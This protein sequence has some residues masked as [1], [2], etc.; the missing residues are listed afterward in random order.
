M[1]VLHNISELIPCSTGLPR[2]ETGRILDAALAWQS[3]RIAWLG[4]ASELPSDFANEDVVDAGGCIVVPGLV[5]A[6]THLCFGGWRADEFEMRCRGVHYLDIARAGGGIMRTVEQTR[7]LDED[8]LF[9]QAR[10]RLAYLTTLG[11]T[12]V[13]CKSGYG[14]TLHDE[15]K[16]LR[17]YARLKALGAARIVSTFLGAHVVPREFRDRREDYVDLVC[18]EMLPAVASE[19]LA[20]YCDVFVEEG[21]FTEDEARRILGTAASLGLGSKLHV[22]QL[23]DVGGAALAAE[24]NAVSADHLEYTGRDGIAKMVEAGVVPVT[25]PVASL[26]LRQPPLDARQWI[27]AGAEVCV[28]T[29]FN[30]GTAPT[31]HLPLAMTLACT[32]NRMTPD[33]ALLG[34][35]RVAAQAIGLEE[36]AGSLEVGRRADFVLVDTPSV[37]HWLYNFEPNRA[38]ATFI[39][40]ARV[41]AR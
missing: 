10:S 9:E 36:E 5:D 25:L 30:P 37:N 15:L 35:T 21:A 22:D 11:V 34:A 38:T 14:L 4:P 27:D 7:A 33:E 39:G 24:L 18:L 20:S 32:M 2:G 16:I 19:E 23:S 41:H 6:H 26:Y 8:A 12:T 3:D 40:G 13:E 31:G 29:D 17:V 28:A 1:P